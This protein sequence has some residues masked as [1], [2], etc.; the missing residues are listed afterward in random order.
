MVQGHID[1]LGRVEHVRNAPEDWRVRIAASDDLMQ[2]ITP[3]GSIT[4]EGVSLTV[5]AV[6]SPKNGSPTWFE[7]ALI[8]TTL[9]LTTLRDLQAGDQVNLETDII[10]R[11][12][13]HWMR[14]YGPL[15]RN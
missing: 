12:V 4:M 14:Y 2:C 7:V 9:D 13:V 6:D 5:A 15:G 3:K 1:G 8:P 11:Q 10:A